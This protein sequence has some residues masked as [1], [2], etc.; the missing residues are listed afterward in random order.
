MIR[1]KNE[2]WVGFIT[3]LVIP[4]AGYAL[5]AFIFEQ[6][7]LIG[8]ASGEGFSPTFRERTLTLVALCFNIIPFNSYQKR[9]QLHSMRGIAI[10]TVIYAVAWVVY[11][12][13]EIL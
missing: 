9:R 8:W 6:I 4:I 5:L 12:G 1:N 10:I 11:F 13:K 3:G 2:L 7:A